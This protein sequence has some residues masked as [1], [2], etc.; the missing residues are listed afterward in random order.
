[1]VEVFEAL[2]CFDAWLLQDTFWDIQTARK[3]CNLLAFVNLRSI[4]IV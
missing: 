2:L 4:E 3:F 1:V